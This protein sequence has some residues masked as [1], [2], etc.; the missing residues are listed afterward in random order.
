[1]TKRIVVGFQERAVISVL[2]KGPPGWE[3]KFIIHPGE[4]PYW[5]IE[6]PQEKARALHRQEMRMWYKLHPG[7]QVE[8]NKRHEEKHP[9]AADEATR[10]SMQNHP[11]TKKRY[12]EKHREQYNN[13][14]KEYYRTPKGKANRARKIAKRRKRSTDPGAY[15]TRVELLHT[16]QES[17]AKCG[18]PYLITHTV[19]HIL[20]LCLGGTDDWDNLQPICVLCHRKKTAEDLVKFRSTVLRNKVKRCKYGRRR[21][22][23]RRHD[24]DD[25]GYNDDGSSQPDTSESSSACSGRR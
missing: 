11:E 15:A 24:G 3:K 6:D 5:E 23:G 20:A 7:A 14:A 1:V 19:D 10:R 2:P 16:I 8:A 13:A 22:D 17:C 21:H 9:G 4:A 25:D 18:A 12:V